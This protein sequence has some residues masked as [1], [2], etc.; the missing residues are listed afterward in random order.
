M[1]AFEGHYAIKSGGL[2]VFAE[3]EFLDCTYE[4]KFLDSL[5]KRIILNLCDS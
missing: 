4:R 2:K 5:S 1:V 3:Q